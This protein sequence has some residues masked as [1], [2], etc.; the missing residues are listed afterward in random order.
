MLPLYPT[1]MLSTM[2]ILR[3][4]KRPD[5]PR[6]LD[7]VRDRIRYKHYSIRTEQAYLDWIRRFIRFH[8]RR[9]SNEMGATEVKAFLTHL[10]V[11]GCVAASTQ[12]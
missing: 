1:S 12:N 9:H 10:A 2:M 6:L 4:P 3:E 5:A 7:Q 11:A 8:A